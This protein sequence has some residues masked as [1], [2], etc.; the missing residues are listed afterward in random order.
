MV[1][2]EDLSG[3]RRDPRVERSRAKVLTAAA[4]LLRE[5]G[6][7]EVTIEQISERSGVSRSTMYRHWT[8]REEILRDAFSHVAVPDPGE[9]GDEAIDLRE[10]LRRYARVFADGL[11]NAWGRAAATLAMTALDDP[12]QRDVIA[13]FTDGYARDVA[14]LLARA[15]ERGETVA[16]HDPAEVADRLVAPLFHRYLFRHL[17]LDDEFVT[18]N[19]DRVAAGLQPGPD[20]DGRVPRAAPTLDTGP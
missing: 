20:D 5:V 9:P 11:E 2:A 16:P 10:D 14:L 7:A 19:A 8:T 4:Q 17:P 1:N 3:E 6:F 15:G 12:A 18:S 13:T